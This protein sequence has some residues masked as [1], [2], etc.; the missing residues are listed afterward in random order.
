MQAPTSEF[1]DAGAPLFADI[2]LRW[3]QYVKGHI[4]S[5]C[6]DGARSH[7]LALWSRHPLSLLPLFCISAFAIR[8]ELGTNMVVTKIATV[9]Q[10]GAIEGKAR[11]QTS[12]LHNDGFG[13]VVGIDNNLYAPFFLADRQALE[14]ESC[15]F[16]DF[17]VPPGLY[18]L[19][20]IGRNRLLLRE[21]II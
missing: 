21:Q 10:Y 19:Y 1:T 20:G 12:S 16:C 17:F 13:G 14:V 11:G 3:R 7:S 9:T 6:L 18:R 2:M 15:H 5:L 8:F 4:L